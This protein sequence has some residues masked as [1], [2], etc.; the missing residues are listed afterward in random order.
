MGISRIKYKSDT[1]LYTG[2]SGLEF[3][4]CYTNIFQKFNGIEKFQLQ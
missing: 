4:V 3:G 1:M 2:I